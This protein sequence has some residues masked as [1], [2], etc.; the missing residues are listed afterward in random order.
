VPR[1]LDRVEDVAHHQCGEQSGA[2]LNEPVGGGNAQLDPTSH[3][4]C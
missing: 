1:E 2:E 3:Q 4:H